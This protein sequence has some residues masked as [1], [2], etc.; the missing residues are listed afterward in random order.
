MVGLRAYAIDNTSP[1]SYNVTIETMRRNPSDL[2]VQLT[3]V[4]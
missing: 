2:D 1:P 4:R 3:G